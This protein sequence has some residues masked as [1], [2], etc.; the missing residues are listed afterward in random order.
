MATIRQLRGDYYPCVYIKV[1]P[2]L[3][4]NPRI[5]CDYVYEIQP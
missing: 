4:L 5:D 2:L 1:K 3:K